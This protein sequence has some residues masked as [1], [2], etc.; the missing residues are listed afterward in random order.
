MTG[1]AFRYTDAGKSLVTGHVDGSLCVWNSATGEMRKRIKGHKGIVSAIGVSSD[2]LTFASGGIDGLVRIWDSRS[3][4]SLST[5]KLHSDAVTD[6]CFDQT[7]GLLG[8]LSRDG[9]IGV[10]DI[11]K[12]KEILTLETSKNAMRKITLSRSG[13][14]LTTFDGNLPAQVRDTRSGESLYRFP[15]QLRPSAIALDGTSILAVSRS[16]ESKFVVT[17]YECGI[18]GKYTYTSKEAVGCDQSDAC[19]FALSEDGTIFASQFDGALNCD[20]MGG[21]V[22]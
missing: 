10:T 21:R 19:Y 7:G 14:L 18:G 11:R 3:G 15:D 6:L 2:G 16:A 5:V 12:Q 9:K 17:R 8:S 22:C 20:N 4:E 13:Q 1:T